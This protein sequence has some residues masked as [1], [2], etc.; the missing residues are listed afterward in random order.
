[1]LRRGH[2]NVYFHVVGGFDES[3]LDVSEL[4]GR[5][6]FYGKQQGEWFDY[7]YQDKDAILSPNV[8]DVLAPGAFDGF[9][10]ASCTEAALREVAILATDPLQMNEGRFVQGEEIDILPHEAELW[11]E[12]VEYYLQNP[13]KLRDLAKG[14]ARAVRRIYSVEKQIRPRVALLQQ[15][16]ERARSKRKELTKRLQQF[17]KLKNVQY[18]VL[19]RDGTYEK[20]L[21][22][23]SFNIYLDGDLFKATIIFPEADC[24]Q[25][26]E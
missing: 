5:I 6:F 12:K 19:G 24:R 11:T 25:E 22:K 2:E 23:G 20:E 18:K 17:S 3:V 16:L 15:E 10:T 13:A 14:S 21:Q 9:P 8:P 4:E 7:F 26:K 1:M